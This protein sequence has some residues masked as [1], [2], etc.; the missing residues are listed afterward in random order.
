MK[1]S[2][3]HSNG[4]LF[5]GTR[6]DNA[7]RFDV[8]K[9]HD[10]EIDSLFKDNKFRLGNYTNKNGSLLSVNQEVRALFSRITRHEIYAQSSSTDA[11]EEQLRQV[12]KEQE[13]IVHSSTVMEVDLDDEVDMEEYAD[14][15]EKIT[16]E[17]A[18]GDKE[19]LEKLREAYENAKRSLRA[20]LPEK[21]QEEAARFENRLDEKFDRLIKAEKLEK[22]DF[23]SKLELKHES[24]RESLYFELLA[25]PFRVKE[26]EIVLRIDTQTQVDGF[27]EPSYV[28]VEKT[29]D[30]LKQLSRDILEQGLASVEELKSAFANGYNEAVPNNFAYRLQ[31]ATYEEM[32]RFFDE[33]K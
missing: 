9:L 3:S 19:E 14:Y 22:P 31:S 23:S 10:R 29:T 15:I 13:Y 17:L 20:Q 2:T 4:W 11:T 7:R 18:D 33:W 32:M 28:S 8:Q 5:T 26:P 30:R 21:Y 12:L 25:E 27:K 24:Q 1:I 16:L 6:N